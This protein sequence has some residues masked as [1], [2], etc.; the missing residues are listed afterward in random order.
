MLCPP[1]WRWGLTLPL[2]RQSIPA[3]PTNASDQVSVRQS[4][5]CLPPHSM[6][7]ITCQ[8][9]MTLLSTLR[10]GEGGGESDD[11]WERRMDEETDAVTLP[12]SPPQA[13]CMPGDHLC[14]HNN[15]SNDS[16]HDYDGRNFQWRK[17]CSTELFHRFNCGDHGAADNDDSCDC[18]INSIG[19]DDDN[20]SNDDGDANF[21]WSKDCSAELFHRG[22]M[23]AEQKFASGERAGRYPRDSLEECGAWFKW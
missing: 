7:M 10:G 16:V 21:Q 14:W 23:A 22:L 13:I 4:Y 6:I 9:T 5:F 8:S 3:T 11:D 18:V 17:D 15:A 12:A 2:S 1:I 19:N 20:A